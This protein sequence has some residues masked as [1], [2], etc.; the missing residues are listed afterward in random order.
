MRAT[1][2]VS[3]IF[4]TLLYGCSILTGGRDPEGWALRHMMLADSLEHA[5]MFRQASMEYVIVAQ[6]YK[7]TSYYPRAVMK[8]AY[9]NM[10]P[11]NPARSDSTALSWI[12]VYLSLPLTNEEVENARMYYTLLQRIRFIQTDIDRQTFV[13]DSLQAAFKRQATDSSALT[14]RIQELEVDLKQATD[15]LA[16]LKE[17]DV[18]LSKARGKK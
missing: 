13:A 1:S 6:H 7:G 16:K 5:S 2:L 12:T 17:V 14:R 9:L 18:R 10:N 11:L 8:L 4:L 15:E 3:I